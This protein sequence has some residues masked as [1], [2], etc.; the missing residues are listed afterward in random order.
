MRKQVKVLI[1]PAGEI[2]SVELHDALSTNVNIKVFGASSIDRHGPYLFKNYYTGLPLISEPSF[3]ESFN[4]LLQLNEIDIVMP[5]HDTVALFLASHRDG[6]CATVL[7]ADLKTNQVCRDK[8]LTYSLFADCKFCPETQTRPSTFP[9]FVK[10]RIGQGSVGVQLL[11][12]ASDIPVG[13]NW[14]DYVV[15]E[16][17]PGQELTVDCLTDRKGVLRVVLPR[18][19]TRVMA[20]VSVAGTALQASDDIQMIAEAINERLAFFGLWYFQL[21]RDKN[22]QFK[23]LEVSSRCAGA[24]CLSRARGINLPLLSVY[25]ALGRDITVFENPYAVSMDRTLVSRYKIDYSYDTV[26][27]DYDDTIIIDGEVCLPVMRFLYQCRNRG[28][29]IILLTRHNEDHEDRLLDNMKRFA[30]A[31]E[32][33]D[34]IIELSLDEKKYD[35]IIPHRAVFID[36][37]YKERLLVHSKHNIPVFDVD[38]VEV[39]ADWRC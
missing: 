35:Y 33:F 32:L 37:A 12:K 10:P 25:I 38:G 9:C 27:I 7:T 28:K 13:I 8:A 18:E 17:L 14:G 29:R 26:Y 34:Q 31:P 19:R 21:K 39:L 2:N 3:C 24:M 23:L 11:K 22:G 36:N 1:F 20:G 15:C 30:I 16:Y 4:K 5:T 6:I